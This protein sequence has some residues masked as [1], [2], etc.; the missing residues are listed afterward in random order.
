MNNRYND[1]AIAYLEKLRWQ[2]KPKCTSC[3]SLQTSRKKKSFRHTCLY[4]KNSF[5]VLVG[6]IFESTKLPLKKWFKAIEIILKS[7]KGISS[8]QLS[9][10]IDVNKNTAWLMQMKIRSAMLKKQNAF[11]RYI[12][13]N[14]HNY[15][16][17]ENSKEILTSVK[18]N[19]YPTKKHLILLTNRSIQGQF[20]RLNLQYYNSYCNEVEYKYLMKEKPNRGYYDLMNRM[21]NIKFNFFIKIMPSPIKAIFICYP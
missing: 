17:K 6:T 8:L 16:K 3:G 4:C 11:M 10:L 15:H 13:S 18:L 21:L 14:L 20:H 5:S 7:S 1:P 12:K 2:D 9:R 19:L